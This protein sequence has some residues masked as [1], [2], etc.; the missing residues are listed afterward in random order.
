MEESD[1]D[2]DNEEEEDEEEE[3][4]EEED[5]NQEESLGKPSETKNTSLPGNSSR[6]SFFSQEKGTKTTLST[7]E[8]VSSGNES[9]VRCSQ[10][11]SLEPEMKWSADS[12]EV[13]VCHSLLRLHRP[14]L[15]SSALST[16]AEKESVRRP[17]MLLAMDLSI[18]K[19]LMPRRKCS[20]SKDS[21]LS[22]GGNNRSLARKH[23]LTKNETSPKSLSYTGEMPSSHQA[24]RESFVLCNSSPRLDISPSRYFSSKRELSS[25]LYLPPARGVSPVRCVSPNREMSSSRYLSLKKMLSQSYSEPP[26]RYP[27]PGREDRPS[28][29]QVAVDDKV[30]NL[31]ET[32]HGISSSVPLPHRSFD[33][34]TELHEDPKLVNCA[35]RWVKIWCSRCFSPATSV[36]S[37][38][39]PYGR[40]L[41][42]P[43]LFFY[44]FAL[45]MV[46]SRTWKWI[47]LGLRFRT[48]HSHD[49]FF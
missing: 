24:L 13:A 11:A 36:V 9:T 45:P 42:C 22:S 38:H 37:H 5:E 33:K 18:S 29:S 28:H 10:T 8:D 2:D 4:E 21:G 15:S 14:A 25:P 19:D 3:E 23:L 12:C 17:Q 16:S 7:V 35:Q 30:Q 40:S 26:S 39:W 49:V 31:R 44:T 41:Y 1:D 27:S 6:S 47:L 32:P 20:P 48:Y 34:D 46:G 43:S